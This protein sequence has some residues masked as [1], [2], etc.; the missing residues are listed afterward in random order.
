MNLNENKCSVTEAQKNDFAFEYPTSSGVIIEEG[1]K[2]ETTKKLQ[3]KYRISRKDNEICACEKW[4]GAYSTKQNVWNDPNRVLHSEFACP[5]SATGE[6]ATL[7]YEDVFSAQ[8]SFPVGQWFYF[9]PKQ[10]GRSTKTIA[11]S[12]DG[13]RICLRPG[14]SYAPT[15]AP[16]PIVF[17][18]NKAFVNVFWDKTKFVTNRCDKDQSYSLNYF[19]ENGNMQTNQNPQNNTQIELTGFSKQYWFALVM[20]SPSYSDYAHVPAIKCETQ[21]SNAFSFTDNPNT[22]TAWTLSWTYNW[23]GANCPDA[24]LNK[25]TDFWVTYKTFRV[26][27]N[28]Q[29]GT[30]ATTQILST[31]ATKYSV[32][33]T[34]TNAGNYGNRGVKA[35]M[36]ISLVHIP[37]GKTINTASREHIFCASTPPTFSSNTIKTTGFS[38]CEVDQT[39][40]SFNVSHPSVSNWGK[41]CGEEVQQFVYF[42]GTDYPRT[43]A[44]NTPV[45]L[46]VSCTKTSLEYCFE[47][48]NSHA[49]KLLC[50]KFSLCKNTLPDAPTNAKVTLNTN[51]LALVN[52]EN[53][54]TLT[55][56]HS[57]KWGNCSDQQI[58]KVFKLNTKTGSATTAITTS[59]KSLGFVVKFPTNQTR[60]SV[61]WDVVAIRDS[62]YKSNK[63]E[64][65]FTACKVTLPGN[66]QLNTISG[67][68]QKEASF[69]WT[70]SYARYDDCAGADSGLSLVYTFT[71]KS[72]SGTV[73]TE[74]TGL[75]ETQWGMSVVDLSGL[76]KWTVKACISRSPSLCGESTSTISVDKCDITL[77]TPDKIDKLPE[78]GEL[79]T[80]ETEEQR[81]MLMIWNTPDWGTICSKEEETRTM[82]LVINKKSGSSWN[83]VLNEPIVNTTSATIQ[84]TVKLEDGEYRL[85]VTAIVSNST[86]S[87]STEIIKARSF[88]VCKFVLPNISFQCSKTRMIINHTTLNVSLPF[89]ATPALK[90]CGA[91]F[92][93]G[94]SGQA[95]DGWSGVLSKKTV[96]TT[97]EDN[98]IKK[99]PLEVSLSELKSRTGN[100]AV[101]FYVQTQYG[102]QN[103]STTASCKQTMCIPYNPPEPALKLTIA[104]DQKGTIKAEWGSNAE[105]IRKSGCDSKAPSYE[106]RLIRDSD[107]TVLAEKASTEDTS[108]TV[109][110]QPSGSYTMIVRVSNGFISSAYV[111]HTVSLCLRENL[112]PASL[113]LPEPGSHPWYTSV[114]FN[115][116]DLPVAKESCS[117]LTSSLVIWDK[118]DESKKHTFLV[119]G[120]QNSR[121]VDSLV[122]G[123][124]YCWTV[125]SQTNT[126]SAN[127]EPYCFTACNEEPR[128]FSVTSNEPSDG[129]VVV[130]W[131]NADQW[132]RWSGSVNSSCDLD[133]VYTLSLSKSQSMSDV[134]PYPTS[135]VT[136]LKMPKLEDGATYWWRVTYASP[137]SRQS[138]HSEVRSFTYC[139]GQEPEAPVVVS[140]GTSAKREQGRFFVATLGN[141]GKSCV[142]GVTDE[143]A[144]SWYNVTIRK[145]GTSTPKTFSARA[146]DETATTDMYGRNCVQIAQVPQDM[147]YGMYDWT[148]TVTNAAGQTVSS[149][150]QALI[151]CDEP[152]TVEL[153]T[154]PLNANTSSE[155]VF[156][157]NKS[158]VSL[159]FPCVENPAESP[160]LT[161]VVR[162]TAT[163]TIVAQRRVTVTMI[164]TGV[165]SWDASEALGAV[166][167][168]GHSYQWSV[169]T[170]NG[171]VTTESEPHDFTVT[172]MTCAMLRCQNGARCASVDDTTS[173]SLSASSSSSSGSKVEY[174]GG[175][176][177][178][179]ECLDGF[180][181]VHCENSKSVNVVAI[182]S[183]VIPAV[184]VLA[185]IIIIVV[186]LLVRKRKREGR[187]RVL[188]KGPSGDLRFSTVKVP[189]KAILSATAMETLHARLLE[190]AE[191]GGFAMSLGIL[192]GTASTQIENTCKAL[193][194]AH[195]HDGNDVAL[196]KALIAHEVETCSKADVIFRANTAATLTFKYLSKM[197][198]LDYLFTTLGKVLRDVM[199][200]DADDAA[201]EEHVRKNKAMAELMVV[202]DTF[203]VDPTKVAESGSAQDYVLSINTLQLTLLVQ[204]FMKQ[205]FQSAE[206]MPAELREVLAA[207]RD[208]VADKYPEAVQRA[209]SAFIFLRFYNCAIAVPE[210]YG[211]LEEPPNERVR[212]TLVLATK[213]LT[214]LSSGA[215]FGEKEE[216]MTQFNELVDSSQSALTAFYTTVCTTGATMLA[217]EE[218]T[219]RTF[220]DTP[221]ELYQD[222]MTVIASSDNESVD[223]D[224]WL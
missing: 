51:Q 93:W 212:R 56:S 60:V 84:K 146:N 135:N 29:I 114:N 187:Q 3:W 2:D 66:P 200:K 85:N 217:E 112:T 216:F 203:E 100:G 82:V 182:L 186:L 211:L 188:L 158:T 161:V 109:S 171:D 75:T 43:S 133:W 95:S 81:S 179:C 96:D 83:N 177:L 167:E 156:A 71:L 58:T 87:H 113:K 34:F 17:F 62:K 157:W 190:D 152:S 223:S 7:G 20:G 13:I 88:T 64:H 189:E 185:A 165:A 138:K 52:S 4:E 47:A 8:P 48:N 131:K 208:D 124:E 184:L 176:E 53:K 45:S 89:T 192:A 21:N 144:S 224:V 44:Q 15:I 134:V 14:V 202:Q 105:Q 174:E 148:A 180:S 178:F 79:I 164:N 30:T 1:D 201:V 147:E 193:L 40:K 123:K 104:D 215:R 99:S 39:E 125:K 209:L 127:S 141:P 140:P 169:V 37:T 76:Y 136:E 197:V 214:T 207:L 57:G 69:K 27:N 106:Y 108:V 59:T 54:V 210:A 130:K 67:T 10:T 220:V 129:I 28:Q 128:H 116:G 150:Q 143:V 33:N 61:A 196:L 213:V 41:T 115:F 107:G 11:T 173:S 172:R 132:F 181:G 194:Y 199:Q 94:V 163:G 16:N 92:T 183:S 55:W 68:I 90:T 222:S 73:I 77:P 159:G 122:G 120:N 38:V 111:E 12:F 142:R 145:R 70:P 153:L 97:T 22:N 166:A 19:F 101:T 80:F 78:D 18:G 72:E 149:E 24:E 49:S 191:T 221:P 36:T 206:H 168:Y 175:V 219:S 195:H 6:Y 218:R 91:Q 9:S 86:F 5:D 154:P 50:N 162:D 65:S 151:V 160:S 23:D 98:G 118:S 46:S 102:T 205:I 35:T 110:N 198:G 119:S 25:N 204:R 155:V 137:Q 121:D 74:E 32:P 26:D 31:S 170:S 126:A 103:P 63:L 139:N 117:V 42:N